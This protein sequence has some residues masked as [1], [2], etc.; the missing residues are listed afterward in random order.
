MQSGGAELG[1]LQ[2]CEAL[3]REGHRSI[4]V[5]SGGRMVSALFDMGAEHI[6]LPVDTKNPLSIRS[7]AVRLEQIIQQERVDLVHARS[8]A[9]AWSCYWAC[10]RAKVPFVTTYHSGY[11]EQNYLKH[12]YNRIMVRGERVIA[13]SNWIASI[14]IR[15]YKLDSNRVVVIHRG[16]DTQI[17][18]PGTI[19]QAREA[20][21]RQEWG[22]DDNTPIVLLPG[23]LARRKGQDN[24]VRAVAEI[25]DR[26][27]PFVCIL[28]GEDQGNTGFRERVEE[29]ARQMGVDDIVRLV[30]HVEDMPAAYAIAT[31]SV[32]AATAPEGF[33]RGMLEAQA[34]ASPVL[35]SNVGPGVEVVRA[36]P[37]YG[38]DE[39]TG[40]NFDGYDVDD[41]AE[42]LVFLLSMPDDQR[43]A[44]GKRGSER[45]R[46]LY[47][48]DRM[49]RAT[50]GLYE[51]VVS[52]VPAH[53][54][55]SGARV[56]TVAQTNRWPT[57]LQII[58]RLD[59]GGAEQTTIDIA[60]AI[61]AAGGRA[62]VAT[63][64]G[65][66]LPALAKNGVE[67][68]PFPAASKN[69]YRMIMNASRL[70]RLCRDKGI[71]VIHARSRAPAW[72]A[73]IAVRGTTIPLVTT[74]HG[75]YNEDHAVKRFYNSVMARSQAIIANSHFT[76]ELV[77]GRYDPDPKL[78][79]VVPRG[80]DLGAFDPAHVDEQRV[81]TLRQTWQLTEG[82]RVILFPARMTSWKGQSVM[83]DAAAI[84]RE[85]GGDDFTVVMVGDAQG[86][87]SYVET[88]HSRVRANGLGDVVRIF[89]HC[90]DMPAAYSLA[91]VA[92]VA[93]TEPEAFGRIPVEAQAMGCPVIVSDI[94][95]TPETVLTPPTVEPD[96]RTGWRVPV[97]D[98]RALADALR[99]V[100]DLSSSEHAALARRA[101]RHVSAR[102]SLDAMAKSTLE[103]YDSIVGSRLAPRLEEVLAPTNARQE[104]PLQPQDRQVS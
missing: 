7:N 78:L 3:V 24:M 67:W 93:S 29:L 80:I 86:R 33:Q 39:A 84:L 2:V 19:D 40:I 42:K 87:L 71:D 72:S 76:A 88:L 32:S 43:R 18:D 101:R 63:E 49:T 65:R 5:S 13:V 100:L 74:Y 103:I 55:S 61:I 68:I 54:V 47:T 91:D 27:P 14:I 79:H 52:E 48:H 11:T 59:A 41:F 81:A 26:V 102:F 96:Q 20:K 22:V 36:P 15:R 8:R 70:Q 104:N 99:Q 23:R 73:L 16:V 34:M 92:V 82:R 35:V 98:A 4:V 57:I 28:A 50:L 69:P 64:G 53:P 94:G 60:R 21:L 17:F 56:G 10:K 62:I 97:G 83:I 66:L 95:A 1:A 30:G 31:V 85:E 38:M 51:E 90:E 89:G 37:R 58:P 77:A 46:N 75:A 44:M 6:K 12:A 9:P 45:I 25:R